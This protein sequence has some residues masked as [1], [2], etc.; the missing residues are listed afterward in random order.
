MIDKLSKYKNA[1]IVVM[2]FVTILGSIYTYGKKIYDKVK[3]YSIMT[4][5]IQ[6]YNRGN[7]I[8][9]GKGNANISGKVVIAEVRFQKVYTEDGRFKDALGY[10][11]KENWVF[12]V[13]GSIEMY[14]TWW[15]ETRLAWIFFDATNGDIEIKNFKFVEDILQQR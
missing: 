5:V 9:V 6:G 12:L 14:A 8:L 7:T 3:V 11:S 4:E 2:F 13:N 10:Y 1:I 15:N